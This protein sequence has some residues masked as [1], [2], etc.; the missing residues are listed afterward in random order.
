MVQMTNDLIKALKDNNK[1]CNS[2]FFSNILKTLMTYYK[3][4]DNGVITKE[5]EIRN[6]YHRVL[7]L[8]QDYFLIIELFKDY[9]EIK[10]Y[11]F[12]IILFEN[13]NNLS[14]IIKSIFHTDYKYFNYINR[15]GEVGFSEIIWNNTELKERN[16]KER[17]IIFGNFD[18]K[19]KLDIPHWVNF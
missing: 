7:L 19:I 1:H 6:C 14:E 17:N 9:I 2:E 5:I 3:N 8:K 4:L 11:S 13:D 15:N 10:I 18:I 12:S 16:L